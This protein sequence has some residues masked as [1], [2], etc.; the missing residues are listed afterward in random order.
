MRFEIAREMGIQFQQATILLFFII[1]DFWAH[2]H[3]DGR[4]QKKTFQTIPCMGFVLILLPNL[5]EHPGW[6][7]YIIYEGP[8]IYW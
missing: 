8:G 3:F 6:F 4:I 7:I 5:N 1:P 2:L